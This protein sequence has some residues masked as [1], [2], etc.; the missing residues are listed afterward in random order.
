[1][2]QINSNP[3]PVRRLELSRIIIEEEMLACE[4][5]VCRPDL[6]DLLAA[7][8]ASRLRLAISTKN[9]E[10]AVN[11]FLEIA[12]VPAGRFNPLI[13]RDS[14]GGLSKPDPR[15]AQHILEVREGPSALAIIH[16]TPA[17]FSPILTCPII[18]LSHVL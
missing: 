7:L 13:T 2:T 5:V 12:V 1:M 10:L 14:L 15:V 8:H 9:C 6:K 3:D 11:K 18:Y 16:Y 17:S 4:R